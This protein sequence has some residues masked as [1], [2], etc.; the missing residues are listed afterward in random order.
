MDCSIGQ[1]L[2]EKPAR[3]VK[4]CN[5]RG[6][7]KNLNIEKIDLDFIDFD[8]LTVVNLQHILMEHGLYLTLQ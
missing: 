2:A 8:I 7:K 6:L 5:F 3:N 1:Y 4:I